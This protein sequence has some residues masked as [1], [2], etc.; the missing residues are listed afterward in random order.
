MSVI[1][2]EAA[3]T[4]PVSEAEATAYA[5][6]PENG[7]DAEQIGMAM[8]AATE[9]VQKH[10]NL[11][12]QPTTFEE[13]FCAWPFYAGVP[14]YLGIIPLSRVPVRDVEA[15]KYL[16]TD[17]NEQTVDEANWYWRRTSEG[18]EIRFK[19]N[20]SFPTV[21]DDDPEPLRVTYSAGYDDPTA[22]GSGDDPN[23]ALPETSRLV[24]LMLTSH[25]YEHREAAM[26]GETHAVVMGA[27]A[28]LDS[29]KV[30]A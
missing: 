22:S 28:I 1:V 5:R 24:V 11:T 12:L 23:L 8:K 6:A 3:T 17:G 18:A 25:W 21:Y 9:F 10:T 13:R 20:Y 2:I 16:D 14:R 19:N 26:A 7:D 27:K 15:V 30:Y 4:Y 29:I